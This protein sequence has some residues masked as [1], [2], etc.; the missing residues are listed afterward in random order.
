L[1]SRK[2]RGKLPDRT[3]ASDRRK[4][5][6][7]NSLIVENF[8]YTPNSITELRRLAETNPELAE[9]IVDAQDR[10]S[11]RFAVSEWLGLGVAGSIAIVAILGFVL[12]VVEL[13]WW[14]SIVFVLVMLAASH[15]LRTIMTGEWSDTSWFGR[16]LKSRGLPP[17]EGED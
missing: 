6:N 11:R 7:P 2:D 4:G 8:H 3:P 9:K 17:E 10:A 15:L 13:G 5:T 16:F 1:S 14:Q 12:I